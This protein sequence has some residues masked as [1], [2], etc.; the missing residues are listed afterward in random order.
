MTRPIPKGVRPDLLDLI[1]PEYDVQSE[2]PA[3][4]TIIICSAPRTG[5][6]ELCRFLLAAGVGIPHEYF[7]PQ[8]VEILRKRWDLPNFGLDPGIRDIYL[9]L[10]KHQRVQNGVFA[11]NMQFWQY[12]DHLQNKTGA[13]LFD[14]AVVVHL[15]RPDI[16]NQTVSWRI[17][18][19]TGTWDFSGRR[20]AEPREYPPTTKENVDLFL[21]DLHFI[22]GEDAGFRKLFAM[23]GIDPIFLTTPQLFHNPKAIVCE[24][25][26]LMCVEPDIPALEAMIASSKPYVP[27]EE[28]RRKAYGEFAADLKKATFSL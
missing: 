22:T 13:A 23:A 11:L 26:R 7:H 4:R 25:A 2:T 27:D 14:N 16:L 21:A 19:N 17:A 10:L 5:S 20:T 6:Y 3:D 8:F 12:S 18:M 28:A 9:Q 1:G 24:L 15:Y